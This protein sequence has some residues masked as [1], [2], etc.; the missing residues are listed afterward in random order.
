MDSMWST[1][2]P[3]R[4]STTALT[5]AGV[6]AIVPVSTINLHGYDFPA[7]AEP[8]VPTE[9]IQAGG[10]N[11]DVKNPTDSS[12][13]YKDPDILLREYQHHTD[14]VEGIRTELRLALARALSNSP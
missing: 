5:T 12:K 3:D 4:A 13:D 10:Y 14:K 2:S 7:P 9:V 11:L 1:P 6:E 8:E